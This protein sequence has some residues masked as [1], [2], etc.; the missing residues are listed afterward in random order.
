MN[1][2]KFIKDGKVTT[3][4]YRIVPVAGEDHVEAEKLKSR[5]PTYLFDELTERLQSGAIEFKL[6][7]Q[8]AEDGDVTDNATAIW[9]EEREIVELGTLKIEKTLGDKES[10]V[11]QKHIIFDPIPRVE[12]VE[13]SDDPLLEVRASVYLIS[14]QQRRAAQDG[15][16]ANGDP[17]EAAKVV[18]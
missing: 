8:I 4:R 1:A 9:P 17:T 10:L 5:S 7:A 18:T 11:Q 16:A 13:P 12:G 14:G 2:F 15:D 6:L 3:L